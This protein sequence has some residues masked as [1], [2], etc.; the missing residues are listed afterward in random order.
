M[1]I[2]GLG[3]DP[4]LSSSS[5]EGMLKCSTWTVCTNIGIYD[6]EVAGVSS[7]NSQCLR[8]F[9]SVY[10]QITAYIMVI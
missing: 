10:G 3:G 2:G 8:R 1:T 5:D 4:G 7:V 9:L 6:G